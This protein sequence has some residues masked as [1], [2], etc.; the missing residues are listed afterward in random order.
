MFFL[1]QHQDYV[2]WFDPWCLV[3]FPR[4][5]DLLSV[6]HAFVHMHLKKLS[7][8]AHLVT[9]TFSAA[10]LLIYHLTCTRT[11]AEIGQF[12]S[13]VVVVVVQYQSWLQLVC[14]FL[15]TKYLL[16]CNL[17]RLTASVEPSQAPAV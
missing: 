14:G 5:C 12:Q 7:L 8:L 10:V 2:S 15:R 3:S 1:L 16:H 4:E 17:C 11:H 9:L 6:S 13:D